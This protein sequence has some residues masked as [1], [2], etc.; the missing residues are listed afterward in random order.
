[1]RVL[2]GFALVVL[3]FSCSPSRAADA[4]AARPATTQAVAAPVAVEKAEPKVEY[5]YFDPKNLPDPP[6]PLE[7]GEAAV[8]VYRYGV[9]VDSK[10]TYRA[11]ATPVKDG[12]TKLDVKIDRVSLRLSLAVTIWLPENATPRLK[13]HE[14][15]HRQIAQHYYATADA[16][17]RGM[18]EKL[19]GRSASGEGK[20]AQAAGQAAVE[21]VNQA[22][23]DRYLD[24]LNVPC[25]RAQAAFDRLTDHGRKERPTAEEGVK[26]A[27]REAGAK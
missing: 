16:V 10:Y 3:I 7:A 17:A 21:R 24:A 19:I 1:M 6:P 25:E 9:Q 8:C 5:K 20:D 11:P 22:L 12:V 23:C 4:P 14:E 15:G 13:A 27:I 2:T 26:L 18:A